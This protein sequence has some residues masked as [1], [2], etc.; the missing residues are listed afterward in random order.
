MSKRKKRRTDSN[1]TM[2]GIILGFVGLVG[3]VGL[4][5]FFVYVKKEQ[6]EKDATTNCPITGPAAVHVI[7]IDRSDAISA[8]QAQRVK[9]EFKEYLLHS[10]KYERFDLYVLEGDEKSV[11]EPMASLCN[12]GNSDQANELTENKYLID[13]RFE[14]IFTK[15]LD[16][17]LDELL[18]PNSYK[19]SPLIESIRA[20]AISSFGI[21]LNKNIPRKITIVSDFIQHS[22][23]I[24]HYKGETNFEQFYK[25]PS[26]P[27][28]QPNLRN[29]QVRILYIYRPSAVRKNSDGKETQ[30]QNMAHLSFWEKLFLYSFGDLGDP[31]SDSNNSKK[32]QNLNTK[33]WYEKI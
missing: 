10:Q 26:W 17:K 5:V 18:V 24:S 29:A 8:Q 9:Q 4:V 30:I 2:P 28:I 15:Q 11:L 7:M 3:L 33:P 32:M 20:A 25:T 31:Q 23:Y 14:E 16:K 19:N 27:L 6:V 21:D 22:K 13:R 1:S 12:P